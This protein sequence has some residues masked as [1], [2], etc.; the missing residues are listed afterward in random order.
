MRKPVYFSLISILF[1]VPLIMFGSSQSY[2]ESSPWKKVGGWDV[3]FYPNSRGCL[4]YT[5]FTD[6]IAFFIGLT[7]RD[8]TLNFEMTLMNDKWQSIEDRKEYEVV[9]TLG[10]ESPW[11]LDMTGVKFDNTW[12]M[13]FSTPA[14]SEKAGQS[15]FQKGIA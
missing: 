15:E 9:V 7:K 4:A 3:D 13:S 2:A 10:N 12:G 5:V 14:S 8:D 6:G 11:T 1:I